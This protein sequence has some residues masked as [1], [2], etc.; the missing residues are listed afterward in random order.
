MGNLRQR[1]VPLSAVPA[2]ARVRPVTATGKK[3]SRR[4]SGCG[5]TKTDRRSSPNNPGTFGCLAMTQ[6]QLA[7]CPIGLES[8]I[9][10]TA[11]TS[12][13]LY[14][15]RSSTWTIGAHRRS[16]DIAGLQWPTICPNLAGIDPRRHPDGH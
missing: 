7:P 11:A 8:L 10:H 14:D 4:A 6:S 12:G 5:D 15:L 1:I 3:R 2:G 9:D 16:T 13:D